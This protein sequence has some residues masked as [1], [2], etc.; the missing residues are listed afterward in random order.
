MAQQ[1]DRNFGQPMAT[2]LLSSASAR[3]LQTA[4]QQAQ[5]E[6]QS[7]QAFSSA[8]IESLPVVFAIVGQDEQFVHWNR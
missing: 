6:L 8:L 2:E 5:Q 3:D 4:W 1:R 7:E